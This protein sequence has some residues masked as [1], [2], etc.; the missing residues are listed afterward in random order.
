[1]HPTVTDRIKKGRQGRSPRRPSGPAYTNNTNTLPTIFSF[2]HRSLLRSL[3]L[4]LLLAP[5]I[6][7]LAIAQEGPAKKKVGAGRDALDMDMGGKQ[8]VGA[9][10]VYKKV[11]GRD[12]H[13][14]VLNPVDWKA[15]DRR[16]VIVFFHG[17][18]WMIGKGRPTQFNNQILYFVTRG[19]VC[20]QV[21]YR[22]IPDNR[23]GIPL[24]ACQDAKSSMRWVRAH[25]GE[26]GIDPERIASC[27]ASAGGHLAA[28]V[29]MVD[30]SD[31]PQD[32]LSIPCKPAVMLL[33]N[34]AL[35]QRELTATPAYAAKKMQASA[36]LIEA[37]A[38][39]S[40]FLSVTPDDPPGII[41]VGSEDR[42]LPPVALKAFLELCDQAGVR[43][44]SVV[45]QGEG[46][47]FF[48][49]NDSLDRFFDTTNVLD[50]YLAKLGWI[51]G[52]PTL[53][54]EQVEA[55]AKATPASKSK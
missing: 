50:R 47:S 1:M 22:L 38:T 16:P 6:A 21:E 13:L 20:I 17:G 29:G 27:G 48:S 15:S 32:D 34:P 4:A 19:L 18:G 26:L 24:G 8:P 43:M 12:L 11:E 23:R 46:H 42:I 40:P 39:I 49:V 36:K 30:G 52:A 31:D 25:A 14:Y 44:E 7:P 54:M 28:F 53:T 51:S 3:L 2:M 33:Y 35:L 55:F 10:L 41:Q 37:Y 9:E 45:Y 5:L